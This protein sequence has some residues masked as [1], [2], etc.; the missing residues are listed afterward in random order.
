MQLSNETPASEQPDGEHTA[1]PI[2]KGKKAEE[3]IRV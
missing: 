1:L 3:V 2:S